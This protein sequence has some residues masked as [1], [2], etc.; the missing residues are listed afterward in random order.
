M[1]TTF[2]MLAPGGV[3]VAVEHGV[4]SG[5][6]ERVL[7]KK[8]ISVYAFVQWTMSNV[9]LRLLSSLDECVALGTVIAVLSGPIPLLEALRDDPDRPLL[10][11]CSQSL[12]VPDLKR[13]SSLF[14]C[15]VIGILLQPTSRSQ[16][17]PSRHFCLGDRLVH[18]KCGED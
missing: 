6:A 2:A 17:F 8:P 9:C 16:E 5:L 3:E 14:G 4:S 13:V 18:G 7:A 1:S 10:V 12:G 11:L 15:R